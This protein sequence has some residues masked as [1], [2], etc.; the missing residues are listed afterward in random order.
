MTGVQTCGSSDLLAGG[1]L[2]TAPPGKS[3]ACLFF[4]PFYSGMIDIQKAV[5]IL[6]LFIYLFIYLRLRWVFVA[7]RVLPL[8]AVSGGYSSLR[9]AGFTLGWLVFV[10]EHGL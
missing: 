8:V 2:T 6:N 4:K 1:F 7:A 10:E 3:L 9:C 5:H